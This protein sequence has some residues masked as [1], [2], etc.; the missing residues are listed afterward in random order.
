MR[1]YETIFIA[2]PDLQESVRQTLFDKYKSLLVQQGGLLVDFDDWGNRK[3]AYDIKKKPRGHYVCMTYGGTG[4]AV[5]ELERIFRLDDQIMKYMTILLEKE[6]DPES[7]AAEIEARE[8]QKTPAAEAETEEAEE[9]SE[10]AGSK[11][12]ETDD[13]TAETADSDTQDTPDQEEK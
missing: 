5:K 8:T 4:D 3:L 13:D 6:V 11:P 10:P 2:D 1:R 9:T 7:L 12:A